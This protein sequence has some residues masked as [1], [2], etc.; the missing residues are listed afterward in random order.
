[1]YSSVFL[2]LSRRHSTVDS[3]WWIYT[4][5]VRLPQD[6]FVLTG[7]ERG[8]GA[9]STRPA[10]ALPVH[11]MQHASA[12][13]M[14][15]WKSPSATSSP[16]NRYDVNDHEHLFIQE[17]DDLKLKKLFLQIKHI[18]SEFSNLSRNVDKMHIS[19]K[20]YHFLFP[21]L[22]FHL[23]TIMPFE[24]YPRQRENLLVEKSC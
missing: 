10:R 8:G 14:T 18:P 20:K 13:G 21:K 17:E 16:P 23:K 6:L 15:K 5:Y 9:R 12:Y 22:L 4:K 1:M 11:H 7:G 24:K 3:D 2:S 19:N